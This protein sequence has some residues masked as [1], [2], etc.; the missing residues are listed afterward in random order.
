M[1]VE[2]NAC[3][4]AA[5]YKQCGRTDPRLFASHSRI[6]IDTAVGGRQYKND[7]IN[8]TVCLLQDSNEHIIGYLL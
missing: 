5:A 2:R 4:Q 1:E 3:K 8:G 7:F 6:F